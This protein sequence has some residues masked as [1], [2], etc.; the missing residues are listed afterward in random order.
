MYALCA[1]HIPALRMLILTLSLSV[2]VI[3]PPP[4]VHSETPPCISIRLCVS[5][6]VVCAR[7]CDRWRIKV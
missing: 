7:A 3:S 2:C 6:S 4:E 1:L 5:L